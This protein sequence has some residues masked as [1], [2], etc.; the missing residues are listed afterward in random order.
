MA[1]SNLSRA[2][3]IIWQR[4]GD[5]PNQ[6]VTIKDQKIISVLVND[7]KNAEAQI[8]AEYLRTV[9]SEGADEAAD[10]A[11]KLAYLEELKDLISDIARGLVTIADVRTVAITIPS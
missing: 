8:I 10:E 7:L 9:P 6:V 11:A 1:T 3:V 4:E 2:T 5:P